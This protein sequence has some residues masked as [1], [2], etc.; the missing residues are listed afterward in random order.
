MRPELDNVNVGYKIKRNLILEA[1]AGN[2]ATPDGTW[3]AWT[4]IGIDATNSASLGSAFDGNQ[5]IQYRANF[6]TA[7][8]AY[9]PSLDDITI[10]W[11]YYPTGADYY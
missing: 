2:I 7:N 6:S 10:N 3:T 1:R 4:E 9:S 5:Y 11:Q 8:N